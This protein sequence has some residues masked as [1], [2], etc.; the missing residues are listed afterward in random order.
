LPFGGPD[1]DFE[2]QGGGSVKRIVALV[3]PTPSIQPPLGTP[4]LW[5]LIS[6]L[7]LNYLSLIDEGPDALREILRLHNV[8]ASAGGEKHVEAI[9]AVR[10]EPSV[11][12]LSTPHGLSFARGRRVEIDLDEEQFAGGGAYLFAAVLERF[13]GMYASMNS[14][15]QLAARS[16]QR[17]QPIR[18]W[19]PRAGWKTLA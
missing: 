14:F 3:K 10:S 9:R 11:A 6:Q 13:L 17:R 12:R 7:S 19:P 16:P 8:G 2:M 4:Q 15:T 5:R 18:V 1:G